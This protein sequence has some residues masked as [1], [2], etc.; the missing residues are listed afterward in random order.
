M[1]FLTEFPRDGMTKGGIL[2]A[3]VGTAL[4]T[5]IMTIA[6]VPFGAITAIYLAEYASKNQ[7]SQRPFVLLL[8]SGSGAFNYF[9]IIWIG[10][11]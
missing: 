11:L 3:L 4:M 8:N 6:A 10:F 2:P 5:L 1:E 9:W 7:Y